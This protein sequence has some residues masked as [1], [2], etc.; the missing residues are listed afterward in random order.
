MLCS[1]GSA[2]P[3]M[4]GSNSSST[5]RHQKTEGQNREEEVYGKLLSLMYVPAKKRWGKKD[6]QV[7]RSMREA[8]KKLSE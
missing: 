6:G 4:I 3:A 2:A 1:A 7:R 8:V 5:R